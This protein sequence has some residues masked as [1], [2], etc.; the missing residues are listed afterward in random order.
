MK[1]KFEFQFGRNFTELTAIIT[2][3]CLLVFY[4]VVLLWPQGNPYDFVKLTIPKGA[5]LKVYL[6][7]VF[8]GIEELRVP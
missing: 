4:G 1:Q 5:T 6:L 8:L 2:L 7:N 3:G